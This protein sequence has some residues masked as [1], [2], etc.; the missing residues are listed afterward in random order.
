MMHIS[1]ITRLQWQH[2]SNFGNPTEKIFYQTI[3]TF[4]FKTFLNMPDISVQLCPGL[5]S[6]VLNTGDFYQKEM[7][8]YSKM[9]KCHIYWYNSWT[10]CYFFKKN[11]ITNWKGKQNAF[12]TCCKL[13]LF[14]AIKFITE[15][16]F[17]LLNLLFNVKV[18]S[19]TQ[20]IFIEY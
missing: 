5:I 17:F 14:T 3:S 8:K 9:S 4:E 20:M 10:K 18:V 13:S 16:V 15:K 12:I 7:F 1:N 19:L 2:L 11:S 6:V